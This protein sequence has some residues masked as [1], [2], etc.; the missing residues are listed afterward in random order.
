MKVSLTRA[1]FMVLKKRLFFLLW[2]RLPGCGPAALSESCLAAPECAGES[3]QIRRACVLEMN[4]H[5]CAAR[6]LDLNGAFRKGVGGR[7]NKLD[8]RRPGLSSAR[9]LTD[10]GFEAFF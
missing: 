2:K 7:R 4:P 8:K 3:R 1:P 5:P 6:M 10:G 9:A